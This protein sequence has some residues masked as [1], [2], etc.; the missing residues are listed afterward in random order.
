[1][2]IFK[3]KENQEKRERKIE[4]KFLKKGG[5]FGFF[6]FTES[7]ADVPV[8]DVVFEIMGGKNERDGED[9]IRDFGGDKSAGGSMSY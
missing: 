1:M 7:L 9:W 6:L 5:F 3:E 2:F 4:E 8:G